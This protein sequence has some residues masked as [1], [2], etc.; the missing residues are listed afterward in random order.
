[1]SGWLKALPLTLALAIMLVTASCSSTNLAHLRLINAIPDSQPIDVYINGEPVVTNLAFG[2]ASPD[3]TPASYIQIPS[4]TKTLQSFPRGE[5]TNPI[6]PS[7]TI[8]LNGSTQYTVIGVGLELS[9]AAPIVLIDNNTPPLS[10][11]LDFRIV[12]VS[13][14]T[15][16]GGVDVYFVAPGTDISTFTPQVSG[17]GQGQTTDYKLLPFLQGGYEVIVTKNGGKT[18]LI[19][20]TYNRPAGSITTLVLIDNVGGNNGISQTPLEL[21]DLLD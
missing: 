14:N 15:P 2:E 19:D 7:G 18:P 16:V 3:S 4:G 17:L 6:S 8:A 21:K 11:N 13:I 12:N 10:N 5:T 1:M 9:N 20:Q